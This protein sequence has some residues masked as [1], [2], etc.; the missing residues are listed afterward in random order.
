MDIQ[1]PV[2]NGY[3]ATIQIRKLPNNYTK[4]IPIIA[5]TANA[6]TED[7]EA[8]AK[9]GM[10]DHIPDPQHTT[11]LDRA[12][13]GQKA[14]FHSLAA[15]GAIGRVRLHEGKTKL[16]GSCLGLQ[17]LIPPVLSHKGI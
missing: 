9:A 15:Q 11:G 3:E 12:D 1:M 10:N 2:M 4:N 14:P 5:M 16:L 7:I 8:S 13:R 17:N 6:F